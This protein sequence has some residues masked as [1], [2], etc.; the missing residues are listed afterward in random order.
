MKKNYLFTTLLC[1]LFAGLQS[2]A[3]QKAPMEKV[4]NGKTYKFYEGLAIDKQ[5]TEDGSSKYGFIDTI[6]NI[7]IPLKYDGAQNFSEGLAKVENHD[8]KKQWE[9]LID[10]T[11]REVVPPVKYEVIGSF[12]EG[13][14][15]VRLTEK[16][17][18]GY[19]T[20]YGFINKAGE[21]FLYSMD[22]GNSS[23]Y[24]NMR[25]SAM[26]KLLGYIPVRTADCGAPTMSDVTATLKG[27]TMVIDG[28]GKMCDF[29]AF[30]AP[31]RKN[32]ASIKKL[33]VS[34][35][36]THIGEYAFNGCDK[37]TSVVL[38]AS[39][40]SIG[41]RAFFGCSL[42]TVILPNAA[43]QIGK[44][45]FHGNN[46]ACLI[47]GGKE[48]TYDKA[49]GLTYGGKGQKAPKTYI[50][51][52]SFSANAVLF[53]DTLKIRPASLLGGVMHDYTGG[54][55]ISDISRQHKGY[56]P[57]HPDTLD[58]KV[59]V[60][61]QGIPNIGD[62]AFSDC[63]NL[64]S[65]KIPESVT[66]I[67]KLA[68]F[69]CD[70]LAAIDI[71]NSV[72]QIGP[73]AFLGCDNLTAIDIP[74]GVEQIDDR[75]FASCDKLATVNI[76]ASVKKIDVRVFEDSP[77]ITSIHVS[78]DNPNYISAYGILATKSSGESTVIAT[79]KNVFERLEGTSKYTQDNN[80]LSISGKEGNIKLFMLGTLYY[81]F[82]EAKQH[83]LDSIANG[84]IYGI[85]KYEEMFGA[86]D[87]GMESLYERRNRML[88]TTEF[89]DSETERYKK[90]LYEKKYRSLP[91]FSDYES[92]INFVQ[93]YAK[94][95][96]SKHVQ[97]IISET[98]MTH[99]EELSGTEY[100]IGG[101]KDYV[102]TY[103]LGKK[104]LRTNEYN[105]DKE[106]YN[107]KITDCRKAINSATGKLKEHYVAM[108][109]KLRQFDS[110]IDKQYQDARFE[111]NKQQQEEATAQAVRREKC[112]DCEIDQ[113]K[114][115]LP[116]SEKDWL[117]FTTQTPGKFVM[118]NGDEYK[119]YWDNKGQTWYISTG[120]LQTKDFG[121]FDKMVEHFLKACEDKYCK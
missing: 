42:D 107:K 29:D 48:V 46:L 30:D 87:K 52:H 17:K 110:Y 114:S 69:N 105:A 38:P 4:I 98:P 85:L 25:D 32:R 119:F 33:V 117:G 70:K 1:I 102:N 97:Q 115:R 93:T 16:N 57:W 79:T 53:N 84:N 88:F 49:S 82:N 111:V 66:V 21:E 13:I 96:P 26:I 19:R 43:A 58:I 94:Y 103:W 106:W 64:T 2:F 61:E 20:V 95:D 89:F 104:E 18:D 71:P 100:I 108:E 90:D 5:I 22:H 55:A 11:G 50:S 40:E 109:N 101:H 81:R 7:V 6:G 80:M 78:A 73:G 76:P 83:F 56:A 63:I 44:E 45:A 24:H 41:A 27:N 8:K 23:H 15:D 37:L 86:G 113:S 34:Q 54:G 112:A 62:N 91:Q 72:R 116:K 47:V 92:K 121:S 67:G 9:G 68:F 10:V 12:S 65:V 51:G 35:G 77:N 36:V 14:A 28:Q 60:L 59:V 99:L 75:A 118:K 3:Q 120:L 31:W 39:I 74:N